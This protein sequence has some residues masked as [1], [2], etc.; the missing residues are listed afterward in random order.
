MFG[1]VIKCAEGNRTPSASLKEFAR[2]VWCQW[3]ESSAVGPGSRTD[4]S[5]PTFHRMWR[6]STAFRF[7]VERSSGGSSSSWKLRTYDTEWFLCVICQQYL[8]GHL[9]FICQHR[10][11]DCTIFQHRLIYCCFSIVVDICQHHHRCSQ[12]LQVW[13]YIQSHCITWGGTK[14]GKKPLLGELED[15]LVD[16]VMNRASLGMGFGKKQIFDYTTQLAAKH[17][18]TFKTGRPPE[19]WRRSLKKRKDGLRLRKLEPTA[20]VRHM[21]HEL[22]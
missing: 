21:C 1:A 4:C 10:L 5:W 18:I 19:K 20:A 12:I 8:L 6:I 2:R 13:F 7:V 9:H 11:I 3:C 16:Y 17:K 22:E 15:K 14:C